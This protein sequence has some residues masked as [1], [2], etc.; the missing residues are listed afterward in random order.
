MRDY[1][2]IHSLWFDF[3]SECG[4]FPG[5]AVPV[6]QYG[7]NEKVHP[8]GTD[9]TL[10]DIQVGN[11][12]SIEQKVLTV[13]KVAIFRATPAPEVTSGKPVFEVR[14]GRDWLSQQNRNLNQEL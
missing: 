11:L 3:E 10:L 13:S 5:L 6:D 12:V 14:C 8:I 9:Q 1:A 4:G 2:V 7:F